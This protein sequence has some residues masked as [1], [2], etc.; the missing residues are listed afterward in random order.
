MKDYLVHLTKATHKNLSSYVN[1]NVDFN[2]IPRFYSISENGQVI[3][4][5]DLTA[6]QVLI[7]ILYER[8]VKANNCRTS[9]V[10]GKQKVV[11]FQDISL[12]NVIENIEYEKKFRFNKMKTFDE[13]FSTYRYEPYGIIIPKEN[14]Y[15]HGGTPVIYNSPSNKELFQKLEDIH[16]EWKVVDLNLSDNNPIDWTHEREWR[17]PKDIDFNLEDIQIIVPNRNAFNLLKHYTIGIPNLTIQSS[18]VT[19]LDELRVYINEDFG[20]SSSDIKK[21]KTDLNSIKENIKLLY[22]NNR[23]NHLKCFLNPVYLELEEFL[24]LLSNNI[25]IDKFIQCY[26][27]SYNKL[28]YQAR[29][30]YKSINNHK[31]LDIS[32]IEKI[33]KEFKKILEK[34]CKNEMDIE[35]AIKIHIDEYKFMLDFLD[36]K[37]DELENNVEK[38][39][40]ERYQDLELYSSISHLELYWRSLNIYKLVYHCEA[41]HDDSILSCFIQKEFYRYYL[42]SSLHDAIIDWNETYCNYSNEYLRYYS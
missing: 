32:L 12:K 25:D 29:E 24:N 42:E 20:I 6:L 14:V 8:Q 4:E 34:T 26:K 23:E 15:R 35:E 40:I 31:N 9:C 27:F 30:I 3:F 36:V 5:K 1:E 28:T 22:E 13:N 39:K 10:K 21:H 19:I 37:E 33:A 16:M 11:C 38:Y 7:K 41:S 17:V 18:Q 2:Y